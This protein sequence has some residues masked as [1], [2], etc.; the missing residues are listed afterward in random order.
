MRAY[1]RMVMQ[2]AAAA[3]A[4]APSPRPPLSYPVPWAARV[5]PP[6]LS[7]PAVAPLAPSGS[8]GIAPTSAFARPPPTTASSLLLSPGRVTRPPRILVIV[9]GLPCAGKSTVARQVR[10][11]ESRAGGPSAKIMALDDYFV[12]DGPAPAFVFDAAAEPAHCRSL[13]RAATRTLEE[14]R[15]AVVVV[16]APFATV[17]NSSRCGA[18][19][20]ARATTCSCATSGPP[21]CRWESVSRVWRRGRRI[22]SLEAAWSA[23]QQR[24]RHSRRAGSPRR[25]GCARLSWTR[26]SPLRW[27]RSGAVEVS[28]AVAPQRC[29]H[30]Y[31]RR[32]CYH[33]RHRV[34]APQPTPQRTSSRRPP[35]YRRGLRWRQAL[36]PPM[37]RARGVAAPCGAGG[38]MTTTT[39]A[40]AAGPF[41]PP[42]QK[43]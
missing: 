17:G 8:A 38:T 43:R 6:T 31:R 23:P 7:P 20:S 35:D 13:A 29:R 11:A 24:S 27:P 10:E 5:P 18:R 37:R 16:D 34:P 25:C 22:T 40:V 30:R 2:R 33:H 3:S 28:A 15:A 36:Q 12:S 19:G 32:R 1:N 14:R 9:R 21:P 26:H 4:P 41:V 39:I 42:R